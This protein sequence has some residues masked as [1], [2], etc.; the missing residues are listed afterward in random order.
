MRTSSTLIISEIK[1]DF[2]N[3]DSSLLFSSAEWLKVLKLSY[4][5]KF[6]QVK[7]QETGHFLVFALIENA[8][9]TKLLSIP[10]SDYSGE[11]DLRENEALELIEQLRKKYPGYP[12]YFKSRLK[13]KEALSQSTELL[14]SGVYHR[15]EIMGRSYSELK[16]LQSSSFKR[17]VKKAKKEDIEVGVSHKKQDLEIF[18]ELYFKLRTDKFNIIPQPFSFFHNIFDQFI[19]KDKGFML[20]ASYFKETV[21]V[22]LILEYKN[23]W[24]YKF[25]AS[26][27][28]YLN[29][30]PNNLIFSKLIEMAF[31][32]GI[33]EIDL[34]FSGAG[35]SYKGLR[36]FKRDMAGVEY[37]INIFKWAGDK[38]MERDKGVLEKLTNELIEQDLNIKSIDRFSEILYPY[39]A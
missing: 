23:C 35:E 20:T 6:L 33:E 17:G 9:E 38:S 15:V 3:S 18:Y 36:R 16:N 8:F 7:N 22:I 34:G 27:K 11:K 14:K 10:F 13:D 12:V 19:A 32:K 26:S 29:H 24:Y 25:G 2:S 1:D 5:F 31:N 21:A 39:F 37:P 30:R 28:D 4:N